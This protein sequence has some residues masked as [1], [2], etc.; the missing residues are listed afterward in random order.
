MIMCA[1]NS[2]SGVETPVESYAVQLL[3]Y[4]EYDVDGSF[5]FNQYNYCLPLS[6]LAGQILPSPSFPLVRFSYPSWKRGMRQS[7]L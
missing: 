4:G 5:S 3:I 2:F 7:G 6:I 1:V